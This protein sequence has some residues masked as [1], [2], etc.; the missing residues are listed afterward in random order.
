MKSEVTMGWSIGEP[1][2]AFY[3]RFEP[4]VQSKSQTPRDLKPVR[5]TIF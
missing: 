4:V 2:K 1:L 5:M 3:H